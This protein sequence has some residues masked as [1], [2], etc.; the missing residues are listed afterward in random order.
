MSCVWND[1]PCGDEYERSIEIV[2][3]SFIFLRQRYQR[4]LNV[5]SW[6]SIRKGA[7]F[8]IYAGIIYFNTYLIYAAGFLFGAL[9]MH[10]MPHVTLNISDILVVGHS[11][12]KRKNWWLPLLRRM[13][14]DAQLRPEQQSYCV[15]GSV[16]SSECW[17]SWSHGTR[18][19]ADWWGKLQYLTL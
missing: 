9:L 8:G 2:I 14:G 15:F 3:R 7:A 6:S 19:S 13:I 5:S 11:C 10:S 1:Y 18:F 12:L 17:S 16:H 4:E